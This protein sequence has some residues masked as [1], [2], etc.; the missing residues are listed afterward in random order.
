MMS[1]PNSRPAVNIS[2]NGKDDSMV[3]NDS[4]QLSPTKSAE[5]GIAP[6]R[7]SAEEPSFMPA[8]SD[9]SVPLVSDA[10]VDLE[11]SGNVFLSSS[12]RRHSRFSL[13]R[14]IRSLQLRGFKTRGLKISHRPNKSFN[15]SRFTPEPFRLFSSKPF[16][17]LAYTAV[18]LLAML[19]LIQFIT[20]SF[21]AFVAFFPDELDFVLEHWGE[22]RQPSEYWKHWPT[23]FTADIQPVQCHS[24][25]D[26]WRKVPL[27]EAVSAGCVG[28]EADI[29]L[30]DEELYVGHSTSALTPNR[31]LS[32]LYVNPLV[33][34]LER[35]NPITRF[36]PES[37]TLNGV[38]DTYPDQPLILM[39][40]FKTSGPALWPHVEQQIGPLR[41]R[42]FLTHWNGTDIVPGVVTVVA[43]GN[44]PFD[45]L[46]ANKTYRDIFFDAPLESLVL[47]APSTE[48]ESK[49]TLAVS[50][51]L[52]SSPTITS[53]VEDA[54]SWLP[55]G[56]G[57]DKGQGHS[58]ADPDAELPPYS[59]QNSY[60]A[61]VSFKR[62]IGFL[63]RGQLTKKQLDLI[64]A[65]IKDAHAVGLK[66]RYWGVPSWPRG[67]RN[68]VW[69]VLI[70]EGADML[71]VDDLTGA[72]RRDWRR[73]KGWWY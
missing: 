2:Q 7:F 13:P 3:Y 43:S 26:Y 65:Q 64:R 39:L 32:S 72:T 59:A 15:G 23:D 5:D 8:K 11:N 31:T 17:F 69:H 37:K 20:L 19:G 14:L 48:D 68:H 30:F 38:W 12:H 50:S 28:V 25:N 45:L 27:Y 6:H 56:V 53:T 61:S 22:H 60:Y 24:H 71:N 66:V 4:V 47:D 40:D 35:Q 33:D 73:G 44:A 10:E 34:I 29:W 18:G 49:E 41:T 52:T 16:R 63:W 55:F 67:L 46:T 70:R 36:N 57:K 9:E 62:S 54:I 58:V 1:F 51:T 21:G 42:G